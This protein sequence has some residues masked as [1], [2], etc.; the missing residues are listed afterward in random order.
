MPNTRTVAL[1][2]LLGIISIVTSENTP[3]RTCFRNSAFRVMEQPVSSLRLQWDSWTTSQ[4]TTAVAGIILSEK[5]GYNVSLHAGV[6]SGGVYKALFDGE[7]DLA[8]EVW[9]SGNPVPFKKYAREFVAVVAGEAEEESAVRAYKYTNLFGRSGIFEI[10]QSTN[11]PMLQDSLSSPS[12]Q[13]HFMQENVENPEYGEWSNSSLCSSGNCTVQILHITPTG[14]DEGQVEELVKQLGIPAKVAY[15]GQTA[16]TDAIWSAVTKGTGALV[17]SYEPNTNQHGIPIDSL[18][19]AKI[20]PRLDFKPQQLVKLA[21]PGLKDNYG[22]DALTFIADFDLTKSDYADL[23]KLYDNFQDAQDAACVWIK[24]NPDKW[25]H[26]VKFPERKRAGFVCFPS[27]VLH[28]HCDAV[29][30]QAWALFALQLVL[31][32]AFTAWSFVA[33]HAPKYPDNIRA[34]LDQ[35]ISRASVGSASMEKLPQKKRGNKM[36]TMGVEFVDEVHDV[37]CIFKHIRTYEN[38]ILPNVDASLGLPPAGGNDRWASTLARSA[39][40]PYLFFSSGDGLKSVLLTGVAF[41]FF[42]GALST[43]FYLIVRWQ[44]FQL[45]VVAFQGGHPTRMEGTFMQ[46][47]EKCSGQISGLINAFLLL[48][49]F[50]LLG[51]LG[52]AVSRWRG[53]QDL[54]FWILGSLNSTALVVGSSTNDGA[55]SHASKRLTY[56]VYRYLTVTHILC[57]KVLGMNRWLTALTF[58]DLVRLGL[59]TDYEALV[60]ENDADRAHEIVNSWVA[61]EMFDGSRKDGLLHRRLTCDMATK[62][63]SNIGA[64]HGHFSLGQPNLW[65]GLM[66]LVCDLLVALLVFGNPFSGFLFANGPMQWT[67]VVYTWLT[68]MPYL[69]ASTIVKCLSNPYTSSH[70]MF[71]ATAVIAWGER[72]QFQNLRC[73]FNSVQNHRSVQEHADGHA[74][75]ISSTL[76]P[77]FRKTQPRWLDSKYSSGLTVLCEWHAYNGAAWHAQQKCSTTGLQQKNNT[78]ATRLQQDCNKTATGVLYNSSPVASCRALA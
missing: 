11:A 18:A 75:E 27:G 44:T 43:L 12:G 69:S 19:R 72:T 55:H 42:T 15:L 20:P 54:S 62:I 77:K 2:V 78:T 1:V 49:S 68:V 16:H 28:G 33:R 7:V 56:R 74:I 23:A 39:L 3:L 25:T 26:L 6:S 50:L 61:M 46:I 4:I 71:N 60:L 38:F 14:Y 34:K 52:Y 37:P 29:Y 51:Y 67:V 40:Y 32:V 63:R 9:P 64:F 21:W 13:H 41:G 47:I 48:P 65:S 58:D 73:A 30:A 36:F 57:H 22:G 70:D 5:M 24:E 66:R 31:S 17:Y 45:D 35:A 8:F 10:A 76:P 53:F 59:L